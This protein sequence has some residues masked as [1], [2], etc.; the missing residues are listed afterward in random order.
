M[1][2]CFFGTGT[3]ADRGKLGRKNNT[4]IATQRV[5]F[6][7]TSEKLY[8]TGVYK[9]SIAEQLST[10]RAPKTVRYRHFMFV[11]QASVRIFFVASLHNLV[12]ISTPQ[13]G[14]GV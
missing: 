5:D 14:A 7:T 13:S 1:C 4:S 12:R 6:T 3:T 8:A 2:T 11:L 10:L 9:H